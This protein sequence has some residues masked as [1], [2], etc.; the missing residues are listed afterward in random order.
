MNITVFLG[1]PGSGK[2]TQAKRLSQAHQFVHFSTGDM[3]RAAQAEG[4]QVGIR[5]KTYIDRGELV[6]DAVMIEL[7][8]SALGKLPP[9]SKVI[10]D[11]FPRTVPQAEAL[12]Q[13]KTTQVDKAVYFEMPE[14]ALIAR[15][16]GRRICTKC[17]EPFNVVS[18]PPKKSGICDRCGSA[19]MQR[20]DDE[21]SVVRR[22]LEIFRSQNEGLLNYY[23]GKNKLKAM[24]GDQPV[25]AFQ[26]KLIQLLH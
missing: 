10:L 17:G 19:L 25:E 8:E 9:N 21:E 6:P 2:G 16:T 4:S 5:A 12:D 13:K 3:L 22:R 23:R 7:I 14:P 26:N 18:M 20:P 24:D 15:L 11:G 1:A